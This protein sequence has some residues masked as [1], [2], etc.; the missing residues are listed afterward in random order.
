MDKS[1]EIMLKRTKDVISLY[2]AHK[3]R[4]VSDNGKSTSKADVY[5]LQKCPRGR[6][7]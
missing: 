7:L 4:W 1:Q 6:T 5:V 3:V 2:Q